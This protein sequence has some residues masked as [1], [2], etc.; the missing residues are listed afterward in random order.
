VTVYNEDVVVGYW[1]TRKFSGALP[2]ARV[3]TLQRR[4]E[5]MQRAVRRAR[6]QANLA[7]VV[8]VKIGKTFLEH[9]FQ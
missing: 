8:D 7:E 5:E 6:E 9:L 1:T 2:V 3:R 4:V